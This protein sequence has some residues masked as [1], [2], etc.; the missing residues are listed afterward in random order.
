MVRLFGR[1]KDDSATEPT[2]ASCG[3]TLLPGEWAQTVVR[4][5]GHEVILCSLCAQYEQ[6]QAEEAP[7]PDAPRY[8]D[9]PIPVTGRPAPAA[10]SRSP[11][12]EQSDAFWRALK[13]KDLQIEQLEAQIGQ[14]KAERDA[15]ASQLSFAQQQLDGDAFDQ[16]PASG[17]AAAAAGDRL[18]PSAEPAPHADTPTEALDVLAYAGA[19]AA[20]DDEREGPGNGAAENADAEP[21][22][23]PDDEG[24]GAAG[25][26]PFAHAAAAS[27]SAVAEDA[28]DATAQIPAAV[29]PVVVAAEQQPAETET[30]ADAAGSDAIA[31]DAHVEGEDTAAL[32]QAEIAP[33][34]PEGE[35]AALAAADSYIEPAPLI[36]PAPAGIFFA[37][38]D[39]STGAFT[40]PPTTLFA[41]QARSEGFDFD[42]PAIAPEEQPDA[43][44]AVE[45]SLMQR[46]VDLF[47]VSP[48]PRRVAETS[49]LLG[50]PRVSIVSDDET[51]TAIL[52]WSMAWYEYVVT[53]DDGDVQLRD[54]G[55]DDRSDLQSVGS[56]RADGTIQLDS[57]AGR[58]AAPVRPVPVEAPAPAPI[59]EPDAE[60]AAE[61]AGDETGEQPAADPR[62]V[63]A[64]NPDVIAKSLKGN[65]TDDEAVSWDEMAARD[66][67]WG[68]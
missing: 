49:E 38:D 15:L 7:L 41:E 56:V 43:P 66:F 65:R 25:G 21:A 62:P 64:G 44:N 52:V 68:R 47:N 55:Y 51:V 54:R 16:P 17:A 9:Q 53:L 24:L 11:Q 10:R 29:T 8:A 50:L 14:L 28:D 4:E 3:R 34:S 1:G 60:A 40:E 58:R 36:E 26:V 32:A 35:Q 48:M 39:E 61:P 67:D 5:D 33:G 23:T 63:P 6:P 12:H 18:T 20:T 37:A 30:G 46:G 19:A 2:C 22:G 42:L 57:L 45:L 59:P 31:A 13:D 27:W